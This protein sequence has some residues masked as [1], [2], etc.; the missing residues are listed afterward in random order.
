MPHASIAELA[1]WPGPFDQG[2]VKQSVPALTLVLR[3]LAVAV[4]C[5][6]ST[7]FGFAHKFPPH[8][9]SPLWPTG[10]VLFS[11]LVITP[12][13]HWGAYILA[14]YAT[15][16]FNDVRAGFPLSAALFIAAGLLEILI[17]AVGVRR[18]SDGVR[19]FNRLR[20]LVT[21]L[22]I[23]VVV[24]PCLSAFVAAFAGSAENY[25][26][27]WRVWLLSEALA[28]LMLAPAILTWIGGAKISLN[29]LT[30]MRSV[31][32]VLIGCGLLGVTIRVF[33]WP[34][35]SDVRVPALL[36]LPMPLLLWAAIRFGPRG[37]S[38][39]L[40]LLAV[41]SISGAVHGLG[42]FISGTS[43]ENVLAL[44]LFLITA[45]TPLLF[46]AA[47]IS[48]GRQRT[49]DLSESESRF[50]SMADTAPVMIWMAGTDKRCIYFNRRWLDF[51][52]RKLEQE[53]GEGWV[54]CV[55]PDD[56][57][58]C[59]KTYLKAFDA[60]LDFEMEYRLRRHD[61]EFRWI[62][63]HGVPRLE[64]DGHFA[65]YIGSCLDITDRKQAELELQE[66]RRELAHL[67]RVAVLGEL[68]GAL[69]HEL[70]QPLTA[71]LS[72]AQAAQRF[73]AQDP[74]NLSEVEEILVDIVDEDK[75]AGEVIRRLRALLKKG[76][77]QF[78][79][80]D[81][82]EIAGEVIGLTHSDA[83]SRSILVHSEL[84]PDLPAVRGDRI[85]LQQVLM[86]LIL[87]ACDA[88]EDGASQAH[89]LSIVTRPDG[90]SMVRVLIADSGKG[91]PPANSER[92]FEPFFT[93]KPHGL[94]LGLT[95]CRSI[96]AAHGG[97]LSAV[98]NPDCGATFC[99]AL[100]IQAGVRE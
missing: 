10:A 50:R 84:S 78:Q 5:H 75:R 20:S 30:T 100:P 71:I 87:N 4:V 7:Q 80:L 24:A 51:T 81:L 65:G 68:S 82:N 18:F 77:T 64:A 11:V 69:A 38:S 91:I 48:E 62:L 16:V 32:A 25:W 66:Q 26:F 3:I 19:A 28:F 83:I 60:R 15:S 40:L 47:L 96:V 99:L 41:L 31:E 95:I 79:P 45:S 43:S 73:L 37:A 70:N 49:I 94:G 8:Y 9:I 98:N 58:R 56:R 53:L 14:A 23:A 57:E 88:M 33:N 61:G 52:G 39:A 36:Y 35:V 54:E 93:T 46:L 17:A 2:D 89:R 85:Q 72:N 67:S 13:R 42:P 90:D 21:Y 74:V 6:F 27:Y 44:Q 86:N 12:A 97:Q 63:D 34:T 92:L 76:E 29:T 59:M 22:V 55:H 1:T